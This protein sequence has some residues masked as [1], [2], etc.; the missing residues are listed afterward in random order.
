MMNEWL[1]ENHC[2]EQQWYIRRRQTSIFGKWVRDTFGSKAFLMAMLQ[3]GLNMMPSGAPEQA[4][5]F[6]SEADRATKCLE[7]LVAW[8]ALFANLVAHHQSK[9][10]TQE[11][12]QRSGTKRGVSGLTADQREKRARRDRAQRD[13]A[14]A[15]KI[16]AEVNAYWNYDY[17]TF[18][19]PRC[20]NM[21]K[22]WERDFLYDLK[23]GN[24]IKTSPPQSVP[25]VAEL[26]P[27]FSE[28]QNT[29][30]PEPE[31]TTLPGA[32]EPGV[33]FTARCFRAQNFL[34]CQVLPSTHCS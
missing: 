27:I 30:I 2:P 10:S 22:P 4:Q 25:M 6:F 3:T 9:K 13:L 11:A 29:V 17:S 28:C 26:R 33:S 16:Q 20:E 18:R 14:V 24:Y 15:K 5:N 32:S 31:L 21:M 23:S 8:L 1:G 7:E 12:Q 34:Q 19:R